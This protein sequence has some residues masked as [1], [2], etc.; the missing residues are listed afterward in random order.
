VVNFAAATAV[1][2]VDPAP[3]VGCDAATGATFPLGVTTV[4][5]TASDFSGNAVSGTFTVE[6]RDTTAPT[7]ATGPEGTTAE[8]TG[9]GGAVVNYTNP[10]A[11]DA[12]SAPTVVC[13]PPS[14]SQFALGSTAVTCTA[15]DAAGNANAAT[16]AV[17]VVDTVA[18]VVLC[19]TADGVWRA[20]DASIACTASDGG[21]GLLNAADAAF[22][23][24]TNVPAGTETA[25]AATN[26]REVK[27]V[28]GNVT[29]AGPAGGNKVDK[30]APAI[31]I[32]GPA[33]IGYLLNQAAAASYS[34]AD[35]GSGVATCA[36]P[37]ASGGSIDTAT[38]GAKS[39]TVQ[40]ADNVGNT[41]SQTVNYNVV[42]A[43]GGT[44]LGGPSRAILQPVNADGSSVFKQGSTVPAKF[45]VCDANGVSV[46]TPGVVTSFSATSSSNASPAAVNEPIVSTTPDT[47]F[48]WDAAAQQWIF[49]ISTKNLRAGLRYNYT[50]GLNDGSQITFSFSLR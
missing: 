14:G 36:G 16:F 18:P 30:K 50:I 3:L 5:C 35:G 40:A 27:D 44:C 47:A 32:T 23:L 29:T 45:R 11:T 13:V 37:V 25:D 8:A 1:D 34:C 7:W 21:S 46:G 17:T 28:A 38:P 41:A 6:V 31:T 42:Y 22:E 12:V 33:A 20:T 9:P 49:N 2:V 4:A 24:V 39:F 10:T 48:R 19:G 26:S 43:A 15:S